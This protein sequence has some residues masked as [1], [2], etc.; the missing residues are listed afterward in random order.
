MSYY[1]RAG[2]RNG[3]PRLLRF[4]IKK[5]DNVYFRFHFIGQVLRTI[6]STK[7]IMCIVAFIY[8]RSVFDNTYA[9]YVRRTRMQRR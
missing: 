6:L 4:H 7:Y 3:L 5:R 2:R 1:R 8:R 9:E